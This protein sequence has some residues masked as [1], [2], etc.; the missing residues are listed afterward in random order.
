MELTDEIVDQIV[1]GMENQEE[2]F[3]F[4]MREGILLKEEE[5]PEETEEER[6]K[7]YPS[8]PHWRP[9]DGFHMMERFT[10]TLKNPIYREELREALK[11]GRG[12]F[13]RFKDLLKRHEPLERQW[14]FFKE[15]EMRKVV[16]RWYA[17]I[18]GAEETEKL[19][20]EPEETEELLLSDL[21]I[22][23]RVEDIDE[24]DAKIDLSLNE[25]LQRHSP[26]LQELIIDD[27]L[28]MYGAPTGYTVEALLPSGE[29]AG[30]VGGE[31]Y[32]SSGGDL[33]RIAYIFVEPAYRGLGLSRLLFDRIT[34]TAKRMEVKEMVVDLPAGSAFL[35]RELRERGFAEFARSYSLRWADFE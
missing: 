26:E 2:N 15:R 32:S 3:C 5:L 23:E 6:E 20:E 31:I 34:E 18:I 35:E 30:S 14:F 17:G 25:V 29:R 28:A 8:I 12:V 11:G 13:R 4:D 16:R 24:R 7:R 22:V 9:V 27:R 10:G 19:G 33:F 1:F 21:S